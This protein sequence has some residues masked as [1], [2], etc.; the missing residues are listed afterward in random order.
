MLMVLQSDPNFFPTLDRPKYRPIEQLRL[1]VDRYFALHASEQ[2][3]GS[4][5]RNVHLFLHNPPITEKIL[6]HKHH[7]VFLTYR[8]APTV[9][10]SVHGN[11]DGDRTNRKFPP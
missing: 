8:D 7:R 1:W 11:F 5:V 9:C 6:N 2:R 3:R 4:H 10:S